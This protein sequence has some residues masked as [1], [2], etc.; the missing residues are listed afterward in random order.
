MRFRS[1]VHHRFWTMIV[2]DLPETRGIADIDTVERVPGPRDKVWQG[3]LVPGV[4]QEI[5]IYDDV[6]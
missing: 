2:E 5:N 4:C 1:E 6:I 3:L